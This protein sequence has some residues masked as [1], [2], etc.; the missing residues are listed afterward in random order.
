M[1][2]FVPIGCGAKLAIPI[3]S[4]RYMIGKKLK[5]GETMV[6]RE[7]KI[8]KGVSRLAQGLLLLCL[9]SSCEKESFSPSLQESPLMKIFWDQAD[10]VAMDLEPVEG[11]GY[12]L[13]AS[14]S[15]GGI[16]LIRSDLTGNQLWKTSLVEE[17][18]ELE[19]KDMVM[20]PDGG[21]LLMA[22]V[23]DNTFPGRI[24]FIRL[25]GNGNELDRI[26]HQIGRG[27]SI[28]PHPNGG[29][30][31]CGTKH[32]NLNNS[33][34]F[35]FWVEED[36]TLTSVS[37]IELGGMRQDQGVQAIP[38]TGDRTMVFASGSDSLQATG[39]NLNF[40]AI[41]VNDWNQVPVEFW[42][43][44]DSG[45]QI[46]ET[47]IRLHD[48]AWLMGG[49]HYPIAYPFSPSI[50]I[51]K[52]RDALTTEWVYD[53]AGEVPTV[54][55]DIV[56]TTDGDVYILG[57][58]QDSNSGDPDATDILL[59]HLD[60]DGNYLGEETFGGPGRDRAGKFRQGPKGNSIAFS[61]TLQ[62]DFTDQLTLI[63]I[64]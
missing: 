55:R 57:E 3:C 23:K 8:K 46:P 61:A 36:G 5:K 53:Y 38:L 13:L 54:C 4:S 22:N 26:D 39:A 42:R 35:A 12:V 52:Q 9:L 63:Q 58:I 44:K 18:V 48:D 30:L 40:W 19:P 20:T 60:S 64:Q 50:R 29:F 10:E 25:D 37:E 62:I 6:T 47:M 16:R 45:D 28:L 56:E 11:G 32:R 27:E 33:E 51:L 1:M 7:I 14:H 34:A 21:I 59:L 41:I 31:V 43:I 15:P 49:T 17:G 2:I 24:F